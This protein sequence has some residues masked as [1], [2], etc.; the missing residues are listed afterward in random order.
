M[1]RIV[2][3]FVLIAALFFVGINGATAQNK[4]VY[5]DNDTIELRLNNYQ[6]G[7]IQWQLSY[8]SISW[9]AI[10]GEDDVVYR[11]LPD[12]TAYYRSM[13]TFS[14]CPPLTSPVCKV[15]VKPRANAGT[16]LTANYG[17][18][19]NLYG[20]KVNGATYKWTILEG[21]GGVLV[22]DDKPHAYFYGTEPNYK[23]C[24][25][26]TNPSGSNS[27]TIDIRYVHL[28]LNENIVYVDSTDMIMSD[29]TSLVNGLY[30]IAFSDPVP[31]ILDSTILIGVGPQQ[32]L[33]KV[34]SHQRK[35]NVYTMETTPA[36][37]NE[38]IYNGVFSFHLPTLA[39]S[40]AGKGNPIVLD[41]YPT[42]KELTSEAYQKGNYY[43][44]KDAKKS[45][46]ER[47][48][49][50]WNWHFGDYLELPETLLRLKPEFSVEPN[51]VHQIE[52]E[53]AR[54]KYFKMGIANASLVS[55]WELFL[56]GNTE[57]SFSLDKDF[58]HIPDMTALIPIGPVVIPITLAVALNGE[59]ELNLDFGPEYY[60]K[61]QLGWSISSY[62]EKKPD[63]DP[64]IV[65]EQYPVFNIVDENPAEWGD[66]SVKLKAGPKASL[67]I[68][69]SWLGGGGFFKFQPGFSI[70]NCTRPDLKGK[71]TYSKAY[72][73]YTIGAELKL[74]KQPLLSVSKEFP[75]PMKWLERDH[76]VS[77]A[78]INYFGGNGQLYT[79]GEY[80]PE[81]LQVQV[82]GPF[83]L[84]KKKVMVTFEGD[85]EAF[86]DEVLTN[87]H[88]IA[89]TSWKPSAPVSNQPVE[90][91]AHIYDCELK[92]MEGSPVTF[93]ASIDD[94]ECVVS[95]L[96]AKIKF[97]DGWI[98]VEGEGG[99]SPYVYSVDGD[100]Y[101]S[102][103]PSLP[104]EAGRSYTFYVQDSHGCVRY[105]VYESPSL[106]CFTSG[107]RVTA[108]TENNTIHAT[109][110]GGVT[111]YEFS[112]DGGPYGQSSVFPNQME[113]RH[114]VRVRD[115]MGCEETAHCELYFEYGETTVRL[116][117]TEASNVTSNSAEV[118][119]TIISSGSHTVNKHGVCWSTHHAPTVNDHFELAQ[120]ISYPFNC[121]MTGLDA[122]K[123][124][125]YRSFIV[126]EEGTKYSK[127]RSLHTYG[128]NE[129]PQISTKAVTDVVGTTAVCGGEISSNGGSPITQR[130]VCW[131]F[132]L[133]PTIED[134][135]KDYDGG[136]N[137]FSCTMSG[138]LPGLPYYVRAYAMNSNGI[139]YGEN[140]PFTAG[141][142][143]SDGEPAELRYCNNDF[144]TCYA[145][146]GA[147][148]WWGIKIP[149][150][151]LQSYDGQRLSKIGVYTPIEYSTPGIH[152]GGDYIARVYV[153]GDD[154]PRTL[155]ST[156]E[157]TL[158]ADNSWHDLTL[159]DNVVVDASENL[160]VTFHTN[161]VARPMTSSSNYGGPDAAWMSDDGLNWY[162][163]SDYNWMIRGLFEDNSGNGSYFQYCGDY[164][165]S[166]GVW[167][168]VAYWGIRF[169]AGSLSQVNGQSLTKVGLY[170][171]TDGTFGLTF[172]GNYSARV[173]YD[174]ADAPGVLVSSVSEYINGQN[175]WYDLSLPVPVIIDASRDLWLTFYTNEVRYPRTATPYMG[176]PDSEW[177]SFDGI[178]WDHFLPYDNYSSS[179]MIRGLVNT[180][181]DGDQG[182][183]IQLNNSNPKVDSNKD[184]SVK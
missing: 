104:L 96:Q 39:D 79:L 36:A 175:A 122:S 31:E 10:D 142:S 115:H 132:S 87:E 135:H 99:F 35:N 16:D 80:V 121:Q 41:R 143:G 91:R 53:H 137:S 27:D 161:N 97:N 117:V 180:G 70:N 43:F 116:Y 64:K 4:I 50:E 149:A 7:I 60:T 111:P 172:S 23:V 42:R 164:Y 24:Y 133:N 68:G 168:G 120:D 162:T 110:L 182:T 86:P 90:L 75:F 62:V 21:E 65:C 92:E 54:L 78:Y 126:N 177:S 3:Y 171:P 18:G 71:K 8:D 83:F 95:T 88:G 13:L 61:T 147:P 114:F 33:L 20:N 152:Y 140:M 167:G 125:Y 181:K 2:T 174:G 55:T 176:N 82:L 48:G 100:Q 22:D 166:A 136:G 129:I 112:I 30:I 29:S 85:G 47:D 28:E 130:G 56:F 155:M 102:V 9:I 169:P 138:L 159:P 128:N 113:G 148:C 154:G 11:F 107:L 184:R 52:I 44:I 34:L 72:F 19:L 118:T 57:F 25:T 106:D 69:N 12:Q 108:W 170:V 131:S 37:L 59:I 38:V 179:Y 144:E 173:Y 46:L 1:K 66:F 6:Y 150:Y 73:S 153:G 45:G 163:V 103:A 15:I 109:A 145:S 76:L 81:P 101:E 157:T 5:A 146:I 63:E 123:T 158:P 84:P 105:A 32:F 14:M 74:F 51:I 160:W 124:Y 183:W 94:N 141:Q 67:L 178:S 26:V 98:S 151:S 89:S 93:Y 58:T 127:E 156:I 49:W 77:P 134:Y 165:Q 139:G 40:I 119:A 17:D